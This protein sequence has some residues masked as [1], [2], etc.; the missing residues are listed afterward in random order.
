LSRVS[1]KLSCTVL[2][3]GVT[4][5][6]N[7]LLDPTRDTPRLITSRDNE[8]FAFAGLWESWG[9]KE[10][11]KVETFTILTCAPNEFMATIHNRMPVIL[12]QDSWAT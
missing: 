4:G 8:P 7:S 3:E 6:G 10:G 1:W 12:A 2:R 11:D 5:N 9:P